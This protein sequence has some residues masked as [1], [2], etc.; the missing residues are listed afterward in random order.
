[1]KEEGPRGRGLVPRQGIGAHGLRGAALIVDEE[2][3]AFDRPEDE[4]GRPAE[5]ES[6]E[7]FLQKKPAE[8]R[9][10]ARR[11]RRKDG[12]GGHHRRMHDEIERHHHGRTDRHVQDG[13]PH[14]GRHG[15]KDHE[16]RGAQ[17]KGLKMRRQVVLQQK[18][19][20]PARP[21]AQKVKTV[22]DFACEAQDFPRHPAAQDEDRP[23]D[24]D[25]LHA[26][27]ERLFLQL[28]HRLNE[29]QQNP[30]HR[31]DQDGRK[32]NHENEVETLARI[33]HRHRVHQEASV[34]R[35]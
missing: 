25:E 14:E 29:T 28:R 17:E 24:G 34:G 12:H 27:D 7:D 30:D 35:K 10:R 31:S 20:H 6:E 8:E 33:F 19:E 4:P 9:E 18:V 26:E 13:V 23:D 21:L 1:M 22:E 2:P 32:R 3:R 15:G 16:P 11:E 5:D